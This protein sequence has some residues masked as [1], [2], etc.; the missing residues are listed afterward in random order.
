FIIFSSTV[1]LVES[2]PFHLRSLAPLGMH[3]VN[4]IFTAMC[5]M[6]HESLKMSDVC[7]MAMA[8]YLIGMIITFYATDESLC[9]LIIRGQLPD[10]QKQILKGEN[11]LCDREGGDQKIYRRMAKK[12][13]EDICF[14][15]VD[16]DEL[17][18]IYFLRNFFKSAVVLETILA[19]IFAVTAGILDFEMMQLMAE[20]F[21][22]IYVIFIGKVRNF[23]STMR[24]RKPSLTANRVKVLSSLQC[25]ILLSLA[26]RKIMVKFK[27]NRYVAQ[28]CK[29]SDSMFP[30]AMIFSS[31]IDGLSATKIASYFGFGIGGMKDLLPFSL[32][33]LFHLAVA[34][35]AHFRLRDTIPFSLYLIDLLPLSERPSYCSVKARVGE[36]D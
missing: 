26:V 30:A 18:I 6:L 24:L 22:N 9:H 16:T 1:S 25:I 14:L 10:V 17:S 23:L 20:H 32:V 11:E 36:E 29:I 7:Y 35:Y 28:V 21:A 4:A 5:M 8:F 27:K 12:V 33:Y 13:Y 19:C 31:F 2:L 3:L 34:L 15:W